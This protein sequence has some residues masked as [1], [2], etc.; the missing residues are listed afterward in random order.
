MKNKVL[1]ATIGC[2]LLMAGC[3]SAAVPAE[4]TQEV[5]TEASAE[6]SVEEVADAG[7]QDSTDVADDGF[8]DEE[9]SLG[10]E[11]A[12][13]ENGKISNG[14]MSITMPA[15]LA[16]TYIAFV[17]DDEINIYDK[18]SYDA[19][20]GGF[21]FGVCSTDDYAQYGGMRTKIG[22][23]TDKDGKVYHILL[24]ESSDVQ[25]DYTKAEEM[26]ASYKAL[27]DQKREIAS[28]VESE[29]GGTYVD[30]AGTKGE[31]IYGDLVKE[32]IEEIKN[33][34]DSN[35][36]ESEDLSPVYYAMTQGANPQ[37]PME[38][39]GVAYTDFNLDGVDEMVM[40]EIENGQVYDI[41]SSVNGKGTHVVS[42]HWRDY[43]KIFGSVVAEYTSEGAGVSVISTYDVLPNSTEMF[44]QYSI[45][46]DESEGAQ[47]KWSVSYDN[48]DTWEEL[49][50]EDYNI[51]LSNIE[52]TP[53]GKEL[54]FKPLSSFK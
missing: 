25:W 16:G 28:T 17:K 3:G 36:L 51:R 30:G 41:F 19:G 37:D 12:P 15:D 6:A 22:E 34:K 2:A 13:D 5:S 54:D 7:N 53:E 8:I 42:G 9:L 46:L 14:F 47:Y 49:S 52:Y 50:E 33:A 35:E 32:I 48:G 23:L 31:E 20:F 1:L 10:E 44:P 38:A 43:Y 39:I 40:G 11:T 27:F 24:S 29:D 4:T 21:V 26:P 18:E 45:K